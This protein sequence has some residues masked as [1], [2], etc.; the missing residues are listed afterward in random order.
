MKLGGG[1]DD[2]YG[3]E[4][5]SME[6]NYNNNN[7]LTVDKHKAKAD[8]KVG[9]DGPTNAGGHATRRVRA[10]WWRGM[11]GTGREETP[12]LGIIL[13]VVQARG[14]AQQTRQLGTG[15]REE[16]DSLEIEQHEKNVSNGEDVIGANETEKVDKVVLQ[17]APAGV[18]DAEVEQCF[19][20]TSHR[21]HEA[22]KDVEDSLA[23][24]AQPAE[25]SLEG[26]H[27][28]QC[29]LHG[30]QSKYQL[31]PAWLVAL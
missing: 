16:I 4:F 1:E 14:D 7:N 10:R 26:E 21:A 25:I 29:P 19:L 18:E 15:V 24:R 8:A 27:L 5:N 23:K 11:V 31:A 2:H 6:F 28:A 13:P 22:E 17:S 12:N 9:T 30:E 20:H 3:H